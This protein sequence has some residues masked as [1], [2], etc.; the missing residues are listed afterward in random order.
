MKQNNR[1]IKQ[2]KIDI[3]NFLKDMQRILEKNTGIR[4]H[5][6]EPPEIPG[7]EICNIWTKELDG[8]VGQQKM[9]TGSAHSMI[10]LRGS[11]RKHHERTG[12]YER[13]VQRLK[14]KNKCQLAE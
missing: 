7:W 9:K 10:R 13:N 6:G 11:P 14:S 8:Q 2:L 4:C 12:T 5:K 1:H 3:L